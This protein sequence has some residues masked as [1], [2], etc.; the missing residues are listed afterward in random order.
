M[1]EKEITVSF[2]KRMP[3]DGEY[4]KFF[5]VA[6]W[7][8]VGLKKPVLYICSENQC[9]VT[10]V[11]SFNDKESAEAFIETMKKFLV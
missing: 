5:G 3:P 9:V 7:S 4:K 1:D 8:D 10:K 6:D 2:R 11:A